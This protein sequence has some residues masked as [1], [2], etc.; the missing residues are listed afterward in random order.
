MGRI[1]RRNPDGNWWGDWTDVTGKR[2]QQSLRTKDKSV[3]QRNLRLAEL[4]KGAGP[5]AEAYRLSEAIDHM[6]TTTCHDK[7]DGTREMYEKKGRRILATL[8]DI[9]VNA[10]TLDL[11]SDY[12]RRRLNGDGTPKAASGTVGKELITIR[13]SLNLAAKRGKLVRQVAAVMPDFRAKYTPRERWLPIEQFDA[14]CKELTPD[15]E[16]WVAIATLAGLRSSEVEKVTWEMVDLAGGW[17]RVPGTKTA[18][19]RRR[20]PISPALAHRL[21]LA[22]GRRQPGDEL[23]AG[24]WGNVRRDLHAACARAGI[25]KVS[26]NDL[27]RTFASWL[28]QHG[29]DSQ[30]V[31][32]MMGHS[33]TRMVELVY[34][35]LDDASYR[36]AMA[37][38]PEGLSGSVTTIVTP[39]GHPK[40]SLGH[41]RRTK[42]AKKKRPVSVEKPSD[43]AVPRDGVEPPTRGFS[44]P[45]QD[46]KDEE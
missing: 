42:G 20:V 38:L 10:I 5:R 28:K 16:L 44:V 8:G 33:S 46:G 26:P 2:H 15:R 40:A 45:V 25:P 9:D 7:A 13:R 32:T 6:I 35:R 39:S 23:V 19:S 4:G 29:A 31:A 14:L 27:R 1:Y 12:V 41:S 18:K 11:L 43:F 24:A 3:A 30:A 37:V 36:R 21:R 22:L 17:L 34:G